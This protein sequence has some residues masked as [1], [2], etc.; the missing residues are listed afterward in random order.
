MKHVIAS[1]KDTKPTIMNGEIEKFLGQDYI[2]MIED[3]LELFYPEYNMVI[4]Y[5]PTR[6]GKTWYGDKPLP[7][8]PT[9]GNPV[10]CEVKLFHKLMTNQLSPIRMWAAKR[11]LL[12]S[13]TPETQFIKLL[14]E[15][16]EL[17]Q[18][19]LKKNRMEFSDAI[20]DIVVVLTNLAAMQGMNIEDCI[21]L[22]YNQIK[23]RQ[24]KMENNT[25]VKNK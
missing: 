8:M 17:S 9:V 2:F 1:K 15:V 19:M 18:S 14:E 16:G 20:G 11:G 13:G 6:D 23:D 4:K 21:N 7:I 10:N 5:I 3:Q 22:A 25:F 12:E 24:G